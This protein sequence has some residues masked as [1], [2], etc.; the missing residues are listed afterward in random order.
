MTTHGHLLLRRLARAG[1]VILLAVVGS[2]RAASADASAF[3]TA[4]RAR[5]ATTAKAFEAFAVTCHKAKFFRDRNAAYEVVLLF[6]PDH[7]SAR[8]WLKYRKDA[9]GGWKRGSYKPPRNTKPPG[10][11]H[12]KLRATLAGDFTDAAFELLTKHAKDITPARRQA[13]LRDMVRVAPA[14]E[15]VREALGELLTAE[16]VWILAESVS[17]RARREAILKQAKICLAAVPSPKPER[18]TQADNAL[19]LR[20]TAIFQAPKV[21]LMGTAP[22]PELLQAVRRIEACYPLCTFVLGPSKRKVKPM[23]VYLLSGSTDRTTILANHPKTND[24]YRAWAAKRQSSWFPK[25]SHM[26]IYG[27]DQGMRLEWCSRQVM[28]S[29]LSVRTGVRGEPGWAF[30]GHGLYLSNL[31]AGQRRTFFVKRTEYGDQGKHKDDLWEH[32]RK[33]D[34]DWRQE[35]RTLLAGPRAPDLRLLL[36]KKLNAMNTEDMLASFALAAFLLEGR[37]GE[38]AKILEAVGRGKQDSVKVLSAAGLDPAT[39]ILK[40]RRWLD[41]TK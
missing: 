18:P 2:A 32:L 1:A 24:T 8:T 7:R 40:L 13:A 11:E 39:L 12:D 37:P 30:E 26:W 31:I 29:L 20:W 4:W 21:R 28:G 23:V 41:E 3:E 22:K 6:D 14:R 34:T 16:G 15:D 27:S 38:A 5:G 36:G 35:A 17:A 19:K 25:T 10:P 9:K 33:Q